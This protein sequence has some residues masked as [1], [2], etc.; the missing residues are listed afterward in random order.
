MQELDRSKFTEALNKWD[1][2]SGTGSLS[3]P[4]E[5]GSL[6]V[7]L[8]YDHG[9]DLLPETIDTFPVYLAEA[10][11]IADKALAH[12]KKVELVINSRRADFRLIMRDPSISDVTVIGNGCLSAVTL[13]SPEGRI[14]WKNISR[15]TDHLKTGTFTQRFCGSTPRFLNVPLGLM[16]VSSHRH[17]H[18]PLWKY[19]RPKDIVSAENN[20]IKSLLDTDRA[21]YET[22]MSRF[23]Q[24]R[25]VAVSDVPRRLGDKLRALGR[26][27]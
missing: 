24:R 8:A 19:F 16:A 5:C 4:A 12:G 10:N 20:H 6:A 27:I 17:V 23:P 9:R 25:H 1:T 7:L 13:G 26:S 2:L 15:M 18:A 3:V 11:A 21:D 22:I 14:D